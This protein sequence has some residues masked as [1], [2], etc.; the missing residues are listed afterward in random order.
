MNANSGGS[1]IR[2][3]FSRSYTSASSARGLVSGPIGISIIAAPEIRVKYLH[4]DEIGTDYF[5]LWW[6]CHA[7][8][9]EY[10]NGGYNDPDSWLYGLKDWVDNNGSWIYYYSGM[11]LN[12][13]TNAYRFIPDGYYTLDFIYSPKFTWFESGPWIK[14]QFRVGNPPRQVRNAIIKRF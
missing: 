8:V 1:S 2:S 11:D 4:G 3:A 13:M 12:G 7:I 14:K 9:M 10:G 5:N 6:K